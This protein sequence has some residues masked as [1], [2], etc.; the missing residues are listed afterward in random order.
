MKEHVRREL[1]EVYKQYL[2]LHIEGFGEL[3]SLNVLK[4]VLG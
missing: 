4:E 1:L 2:T 3:K